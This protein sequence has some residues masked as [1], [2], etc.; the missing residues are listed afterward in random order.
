M[1]CPSCDNHAQIEFDLHSEG[2]AE[3]IFECAS[4]GALWIADNGHSIM[5]RKVA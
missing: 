1:K 4:C 2:Y 3:N 5:L